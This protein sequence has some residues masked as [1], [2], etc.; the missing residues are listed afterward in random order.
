VIPVEVDNK[1]K[2]SLVDDEMQKL[3]LKKACWSSLRE[4]RRA[5]QVRRGFSAKMFTTDWKSK[6]NF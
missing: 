6:Y 2:N 3:R 1:I 5:G 4:P